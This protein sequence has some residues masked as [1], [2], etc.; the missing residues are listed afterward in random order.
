MQMALRIDK[1]KI[2]GTT[3][4]GLKLDS[5]ICQR[6]KRF[7]PNLGFFTTD[8]VIHVQYH[9]LGTSVELLFFMAWGLN[10]S[11]IDNSTCPVS[12]QLVWYQRFCYVNT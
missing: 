1:G 11:F 5:W 8:E 3:L 9:I 6:T 7:D 10:V 2:S 4:A 12:A